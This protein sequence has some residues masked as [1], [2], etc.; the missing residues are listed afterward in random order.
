M[1]F[2][3]YTHTGFKEIHWFPNIDSL[4]ISILANPKDRYH[5]NL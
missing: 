3:V 1:S 2:T 5:R 4:L